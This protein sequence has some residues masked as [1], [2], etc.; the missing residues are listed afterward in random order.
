MSIADVAAKMSST[1]CV[2]FGKSPFIFNFLREQHANSPIF[3]LLVAVVLL[4]VPLV[5]E[6]KGDTERVSG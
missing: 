4:C 5:R 2:A 3:S 6:K 1:Q